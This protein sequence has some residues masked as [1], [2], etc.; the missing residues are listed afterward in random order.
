M[1]KKM[2]ISWHD[3]ELYL[4]EKV[5]KREL[6]DKKD[7]FVRELLELKEELS[8]Y[9]NDIKVYE[10]ELQLYK[11]RMEKNRELLEGLIRIFPEDTSLNIIINDM[12][13]K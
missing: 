10:V 1:S 8:G 11:E 2:H 12:N 3:I 6:S 4:K 5:T 9:K 13:K 7:H